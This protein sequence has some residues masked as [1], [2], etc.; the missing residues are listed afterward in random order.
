[1]Q[2]LTQFLPA[3]TLLLLDVECSLRELLKVTFMDLLF[4]RVLQTIHVESQPHP[5]TRVHTSTYVMQGAN[6]S[7]YQPMPHEEVFTS[8]FMDRSELDILFRHL[9]KVAYERS[10][11]L[12]KYKRLLSD[13][14]EPLDLVERWFWHQL[15]GGCSTT[16]KGEELSA[17]LRQEL[18]ELSSTLPHLIENEP[19]KALKIL[20]DIKGNVFLL[21]GFDFKLLKRFDE[22]LAP[23]VRNTAYAYDGGDAGVD[24]GLWYLFDTCSDTFD[25]S[26]GNDTSGDGDS[27]C[28][29]DGC[30]GCGGCGGD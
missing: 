30:S 29:G 19:E 8:P 21:E 16:A 10:G 11:G 14:L 17:I 15:F 13:K 6:Y 25:N 5:L 12:R 4:K 2:H 7:S 27:G 28:S 1:M 9:V 18:Q 3:Q 26:C 24:I 23:H 20:G 22:A